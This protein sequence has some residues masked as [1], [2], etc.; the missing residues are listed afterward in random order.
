MLQMA[1]RQAHAAVEV[2]LAS[3]LSAASSCSERV[4]SLVS[5]CR[6][7][8]RA[9]TCKPHHVLSSVSQT[10][11]SSQKFWDG[12]L[13]CLPAPGGCVQGVLWQG[14]TCGGVVR[15][16]RFLAVV[17]LDRWGWAAEALC[18]LFRQGPGTDEPITPAALPQTIA[19]VLAADA[20]R[21]G[22]FALAASPQ[23]WDLSG[24]P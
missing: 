1:P 13:L 6:A 16:V 14:S 22:A 2:Y 7:G 18:C 19:Q 4:L 24:Q 5:R 10:L 21:A 9:L 17:R 23:P 15:V 8:S 11:C 3:C 20:C 12:L